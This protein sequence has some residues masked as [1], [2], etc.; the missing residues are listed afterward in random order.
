VRALQA[1]GALP[2]LLTCVKYKFMSVRVKNWRHTG[3][4]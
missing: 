4:Q 1:R 3:K 2:G